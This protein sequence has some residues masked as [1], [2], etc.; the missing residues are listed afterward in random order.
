MA[1]RRITF[2]RMIFTVSGD[3]KLNPVFGIKKLSETTGNNL[4]RGMENLIH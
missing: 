3:I 4:L 1:K 2:Y